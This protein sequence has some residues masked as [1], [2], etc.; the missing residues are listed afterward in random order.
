[1]GLSMMLIPALGG[2]QSSYYAVGIFE[3]RLLSQH[4]LLEGFD[5]IRSSSPLYSNSSHLH[6][7]F[8]SGGNQPQIKAETQEIQD[9][10]STRSAGTHDNSGRTRDLSSPYSVRTA[11]RT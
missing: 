2:F 3:K 11:K 10:T 5:K 1:M 7:Y 9:N 4:L 6:G 8:H